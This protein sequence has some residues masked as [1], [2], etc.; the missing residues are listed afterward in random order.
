MPECITFK[1]VHSAEYPYSV[2]VR[3]DRNHLMRVHEHIDHFN[4]LAAWCEHMVKNGNV[5]LGRGPIFFSEMNK[6]CCGFN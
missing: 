2:G 1:P 4:H 6:I 5:G 3:F